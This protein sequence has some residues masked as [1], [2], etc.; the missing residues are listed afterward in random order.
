MDAITN[1]IVNIHFFNVIL[2]LAT[3]AI[4]A[5]WGFILFFLKRPMN[6][7]WR[8]ALI[9]TG[10]DTAIQ[11]L[12]GITL[13]L[14]GQRPGPA[15]D[16]LFYLHYVYGTIVVLAIPVAVTYA[17]GGKN[18][19]RDV[20]IFSIAALILVAAAVRALMTGPA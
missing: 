9:V 2:V 4:S 6:R 12:L 16:S 20:L 14:L 7:P 15:G 10:I 5:I 19:R 8:I 17:T 18:Q 13:V 1:V 11:A 3:G